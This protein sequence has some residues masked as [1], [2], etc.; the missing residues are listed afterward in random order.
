MAEAIKTDLKTE[1]PTP[2]ITPIIA[3]DILRYTEGLDPKY[4][5]LI[6]LG[7]AGSYITWLSEA[8]TF[9]MSNTSNPRIQLATVAA[10]N[11]ILSGIGVLG[12][13]A[14]IQ[15]ALGSSEIGKNILSG[16]ESLGKRSLYTEA[17]SRLQW[18]GSSR[19]EFDLSL[20]SLAYKK[21][22]NPLSIIDGFSRCLLPT[23]PGGESGL[24]TR[25]LGFGD[26]E[27]GVVI[28]NM[29]KIPNLSIG[30]VSYEVSKQQTVEGFPVYV[31]AK[32]HFMALTTVAVNK[33]NTYRVFTESKGV[34]SVLIENPKPVAANPVAVKTT[35]LPSLKSGDL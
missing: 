8:F 32:I 34:T 26:G 21:G 4:Q 24:F 12:S 10:I 29:F 7:S 19:L 33:F 14:E 11:S 6:S 25:P 23:S 5:V 3:N 17:M 16:A 20:I 28:G 35:K 22:F 13:T 27:I 30:S 9:S 2:D 31:N 18:V 1:S 15:N